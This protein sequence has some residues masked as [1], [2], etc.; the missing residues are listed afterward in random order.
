MDISE[1]NE[2]SEWHDM[3]SK[4]AAQAYQIRRR[5]FRLFAA[6]THPALRLSTETPAALSRYPCS[7]T[8]RFSE[9]PQ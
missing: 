2:R 4:T 3:A 5:K 1:R 9:S 6:A 8:L 7:T